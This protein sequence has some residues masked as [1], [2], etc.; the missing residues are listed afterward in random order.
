MEVVL[1]KDYILGLVEGKGMSKAEFA[2]KLGIQRQNLEALLTSKKKDINTVLKMSQILG[3]PLNEFLYG[4]EHVPEVQ[5]FIKIDG[6]I[7]EI[8]SKEDLLSIAK[9]LSNE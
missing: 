3:M 1:S 7:R 6:G 2:T 8:T 5:G 9:E 4:E